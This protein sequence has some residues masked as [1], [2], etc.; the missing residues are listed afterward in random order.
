LEILLKFLKLLLMAT[1]LV[2][3][4]NEGAGKS[5]TVRKVAAGGVGVERIL[6]LM[7]PSIQGI[8][9]KRHGETRRAKLYF[10]RDRIG[11]AATK[12][13]EKSVHNTNSN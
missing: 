13:R 5:I 4:K 2:P 8:E 9:V 7:L 10:L 11:K 6:P 12:I 1:R 3:I